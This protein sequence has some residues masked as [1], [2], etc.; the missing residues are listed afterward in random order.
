VAGKGLVG[1]VQV[2]F[3][4]ATLLFLF[5]LL[6]SSAGVLQLPAG[7]LFFNLLGYLLFAVLAASVGAVSPTTQE[8]HQVSA[9]LSLF[10]L[11]PVSCLSL[12]VL[13][14]YSPILVVMSIFPLTSPVLVMERLGLTNIPAWQLAA[15]NSVL[16]LSIA[17]C[18]LLASKIFGVT[19][20]RTGAFDYEDTVQIIRKAQLS[21]WLFLWRILCLLNVS[22]PHI[23]PDGGAGI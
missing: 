14:P 22:F 20:S 21:L 17:G 9:L 2:A 18:M 7:F 23:I 16:A 3:W 5:G 15:S 19:C 10:A 13:N 4:I 6:G 12:V 1:L 8:G 11:L